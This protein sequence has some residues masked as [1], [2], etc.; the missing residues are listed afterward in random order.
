MP[1]AAA[2]AAEPF[3]F[4][5]LWNYSKP[6]ETE[7]AFRALLP[8]AED[9]EDAEYRLQLKTQIARTLGL[10]RRF[11][12]AHVLL[13]EVAAATDEN[14]PVAG[15]RLLLE[16]GR[17]HNSG[18][19]PDEAHPLF[20]EAW[21]AGVAL[22][23][24]FYAVDAAHMLA[25]VSS[26]DE[27]LAWNQRALEHAEASEDPRARRWRASLCN[28]IGWTHHA[29][30]RHTEALE[31]FQR[32]LDAFEEQGK[33]QRI[34]IARWSVA[35]ALRS[36]GR[37]EEALVQQQSLHQEQQRLSPPEE[38]PY[39]RE[40]LGECLLALGRT[41]EAR[42]HFAAAWEMLSQDVG[43]SE[44]E[45]DRLERLRELAGADVP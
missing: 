11:D 44:R 8:A 16:R 25:I 43:L 10:Q 39:V 33:P 28:N 21:R 15:L 38:D 23:E 2:R 27:V 17:A 42:P 36:L 13:D 6:A 20:E 4:E 12:A 29:A 1:S 7:A 5:S 31:S 37:V 14:T 45:P 9:A 30:G 32:A 35:R 41:H 24:D 19:S 34:R 3:D 22:G 18:G 26:G 40:E